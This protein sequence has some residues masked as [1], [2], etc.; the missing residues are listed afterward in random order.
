MTKQVT[1]IS[2]EAACLPHERQSVGVVIVNWNGG[3]DLALC[4]KSLQSGVGGHVEEIVVVDNDSS[5]DSL[6]R[7]G[8]PAGV[9]VIEAG[10]NLGFAAGANLGARQCHS[11]RILFLNPDTRIL[12]GAIDVAVDFLEAHPEVGLVGPL[13]VNESGAWQ[14]SAGRFGVLGHLLLDT[15]FVRRPPNGARFVDWVHGTF[16]LMPRVLF[17]RLGGFDERF[18]MYSE[19]MDLCWRARAA[20]FRTAL[21]AEARVMH[22]G[23]RSGTLRFGEERDAEVVKG[24]MRFYARR[25]KRGH[26]GLFRVVAITKFT[27]KAVLY[28]LAGRR[29]AASRT[30]RVVQACS[31]FVPKDSL[32]AADA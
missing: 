24:E 1:E 31:S 6:R 16:L 21:V 25:G 10:R 26:L 32:V 19:D 17:E 22:Y 27:A 14:P 2:K 20:G 28:T 15:R 11:S 9:T 7:L 23:N 30:W 4:I 5:D 3:G 12:P 8:T 29:A 18:F 13:L